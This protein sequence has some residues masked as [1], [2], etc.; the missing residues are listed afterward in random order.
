MFTLRSNLVYPSIDSR[1]DPRL[2]LVKAS[3]KLFQL[4]LHERGWTETFAQTDRDGLRDNK[5]VQPN[6]TLQGPAEMIS[7]LITYA[8]VRYPDGWEGS[9]VC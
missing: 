5:F 9:G 2:S 4:R 3:S 1:V 7:L 8:S 6:R